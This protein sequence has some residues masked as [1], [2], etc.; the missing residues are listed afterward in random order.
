MKKESKITNEECNCKHK[1][2]PRNEKT[3]Q[4]LQSRL[5]R[6]VGQINGIKKMLDDDRYCNDI[7]VQ[8]SAC[9]KA[10]DSV[11]YLILQEHFETCLVE[12]IAKGNM[13]V[14]DELFDTVK[15]LK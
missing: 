10:L 6:I 1:N 9:K 3:I 4:N 7:L 13:Q 15:N 5:N 12:E 11:S 14:V 8:L 2:T